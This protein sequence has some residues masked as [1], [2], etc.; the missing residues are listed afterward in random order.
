MHARDLS[1][2]RAYNRFE[3]ET[4]KSIAPPTE[5]IG[6]KDS[7][8]ALRLLILSVH[9][10]FLGVKLVVMKPT[11]AVDVAVITRGVALKYTSLPP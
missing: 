9:E 11:E 2:L 8:G 7:L 1:K 3:A 5:I 4:P 6:G 10:S